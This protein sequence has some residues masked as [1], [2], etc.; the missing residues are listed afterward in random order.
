SVDWLCWPRF[1]SPSLFAGVLDARRGGSFRL[2]PVEPHT[3]TR[4]YVERTNVLQTSFRTARGTIRIDDWL[5]V[6]EDQALCRLVTCVEGE[7]ELEAFC[8]PRPDYGAGAP[9]HWQRRGAGLVAGLG[10]GNRLVL[11]G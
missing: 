4:R 3:M 9:L 7:V 11:T 1:D 2:A 10:D 6:G 8:D 5:H